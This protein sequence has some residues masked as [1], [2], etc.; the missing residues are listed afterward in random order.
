MIQVSDD[1]VLYS[2]SVDDIFKILYSLLK[3]EYGG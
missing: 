1:I 3:K 2:L